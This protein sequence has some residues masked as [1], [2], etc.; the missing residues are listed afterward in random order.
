M[1][2]QE[3]DWNLHPETQMPFDP[4]LG[5]LV[6]LT[7]HF[8]NPY[9]EHALIAGLPLVEHKL[10]PELF[11]RAGEKANLSSK[12]IRTDLKQFTTKSLPA[13]L[14]LKNSDACVLAGINNDATY[15]IIKPETGEGQE[16]ISADELSEI[17]T[18]YAIFSKPKYR[19]DERSTEPT[20]LDSKNWFWKVVFSAWPLYS[21]V[22]AASLLINLFALA[23]PLFIM[24]VYDRVVPNQAIETLWV[25]AIGVGIAF[26]FDF[27]LRS[28]RGY[29]IDHAAKRIDLKLS[30]QIFERILGVEMSA[31]PPGVGSLLH[32][33]H[34][35][36]AFREFIT[37]ATISALVDLPFVFIFIGVIALLAGNLAFVPLCIIPIVLLV[38]LL[39]QIP[40][41]KHVKRSF[42]H[43][44]E[45][46][47]VLV[48]SLACSETIKGV[49]AEGPMQR[50]WEAIN[51][52]A[53]KTN[54]KQ[55]LLTNLASNFSTFAQHMT[56]IVVVIAGVYKISN[57]QITMGALIACTILSGRAIAPISQVARLMT[58]YQQA[59]AGLKA[60]DGVMKMPVERPFDKNFLHRP[61]IR[62]DIEFSNVCFSYPN[63]SV[64][65]L[66]DISFKIKAGE[67]VGIIGRTGS[68]KTTI[69]KMILK[70]YQPTE[71]NVLL[72]GTEI[73]QIDPADIRFY[74][75]YV[76]QD[77]VLFHG[78]VKHNITVGSP[79]VGDEAVLRAAN[80]SGI[81]NFVNA[82]PD[83]FDRQVGERGEL[84][85][86]GQRQAIAIARALL[87]D[88][89]V[90][91]FDEPSNAMDDSTTSAFM[92]RIKTILPQKTLVLVT[93]K[94]SL[95]KLVDRL[96][97]V[98]NGKIVLDGPKSQVLSKLSEGKVKAGAHD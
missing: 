81:I 40:L 86:G 83:G 37:S 13:V 63:E 51:Q 52:T 48:E 90:L 15:N 77:V 79:H 70:L 7:K 94:A 22:L 95:L 18:G 32:S 1:F 92:Q 4:L 33:V 19:F 26:G 10:T 14:L 8:D 39:I 5:C 58:S 41:T 9:S 64:P 47:A 21:E 34:S 68:G 57:G 12:I 16:T 96:I 23:S 97:V 43:S 54:I 25:L 29:F 2:N 46:Q 88:P 60:V 67:K 42:Q 31:R 56:S 72:D 20:R 36:D 82:H 87:L 3:K 93:H 27:I 89:P 49:R 28:V 71:G 45:K 44:A 61:T 50:R 74:I 65:T 24:N 91:L 59:K 55:K 75:G 80:L 38:S 35:F 6:V 76:P 85:S 66:T 73:T 53:A 78:S 30:R 69:E 98:D 11:I 62:G 17:Y 84:L